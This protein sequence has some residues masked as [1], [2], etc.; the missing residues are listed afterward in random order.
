MYRALDNYGPARAG[1][2]YEIGLKILHDLLRTSVCILLL[3]SNK[4]RRVLFYIHI[5]YLFV[6]KIYISFIFFMT[7]RKTNHGTCV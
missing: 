6:I 1:P 4:E 3:Y 2:F 5:Y 7:T